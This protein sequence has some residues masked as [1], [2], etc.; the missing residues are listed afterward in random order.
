MLEQ[1]LPEL[2][3]AENAQLLRQ[4]DGMTAEKRLPHALIIEGGD[5]EANGRLARLCARVFLCACEQPLSGECR[6]C[7][8]M[9][10]YGAHADI[11]EVQGTGKTGAV[12]VEAV[13]SLQE[14]ARRVPAEAD[15]QVFLLENC[16]NMLAPAQNAFLK[17][18]EEPPPRVMFIMTC[19]SAMNLL[20]TIRSR[21][22]LLRAAWPDAAPDE[23]VAK[24]ATLAQ[25]LAVALVSER[26]IDAILLTGQFSRPASKNPAV[27]QELAA[28]LSAL[29]GVLRDALVLGAGGSS[30]ESSEAAQQIAR[31]LTPERIAAMLDEIPVL[32]QALRTNAPIPLFT[33][34]MCV[35]L[36][37][38]AG[39]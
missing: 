9:S 27:R 8:I 36:R 10:A 23:S 32:Q 38:A 28:L 15:G 39:R 21:A 33:T 18:F 14:Q 12:S 13:R 20:E 19:A 7:R 34:A 5:P 11:I 37:R 22:C 3:L 24:A 2:A 17:L 35:R 31:T 1:F 16:D 4:L 6:V 30:A 25:Q 26:E 29:R